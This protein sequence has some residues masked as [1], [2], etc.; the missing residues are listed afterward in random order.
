MIISS[1]PFRIS[2]FGGGTDYP[3]WFREHGGAVLGMSIDKNC[4]LSVRELPPF[5]GH[6]SRIVYSQVELINKIEEIKHPVVRSVL[7]EM[8]I[9]KGLEIHHMAD[10]PAR[11]GLGS[12]SSFTV[13]LINAL[14]SM[15][16]VR[17]SKESLANEAIHIEQ[18]V[19]QEVVGNQ[20]Q[21]WA[22]FGG[23]NRIEFSHDGS[24][25]VEPL[26]IDKSIKDELLNSFMLFFTGFSRFSSE[27]AEIQIR[28]IENSQSERHQIREIVD[29]AENVL[30]SR[31]FTIS[32]LGSLLGN[33]W[34][35]KKQFGN[36]VTNKNIDEIYEAGIRAGAYGG[37]LL[38]AGGGG[39][40][41]FIVDPTKR[42]AV[43]DALRGLVH[44]GF[45]LNEEGSKIIFKST[46]V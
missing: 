43:R 25:Q 29:V 44:V 15:E 35:L 37:K 13:G 16:N 1:T 36:N 18:E 20:D 19:L 9:T 33:T 4:F 5:F 28:N 11:S 21:I 30:K 31:S 2:L 8:E 14:N 32:E 6:K 3:Q 42:E 10:L 45:S 7:G 46:A 34:E 26:K 40:L 17:V 12:S 22:A 38:G 27:I 24:F 41:L 23:L 39:F